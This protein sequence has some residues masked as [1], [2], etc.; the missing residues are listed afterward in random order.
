[1]EHAHARRNTLILGCASTGAKFTPLN[2]APTGDDLLDRICTGE[3]IPTALD[4][5]ANEASDLYR[6]GCRYYHYHARNPITREQT[7][8]NEVYQRVSRDVQRRCKD[9]L[10][11]F[12]ASRNGAEVQRNICEF[13]EWERVSQCALPLHLGGAHFVTIQAAIELQVICDLERKRGGLD[14]VFAS[15]PAFLEALGRFEPSAREEMAKLDTNSTSKGADYGSTSPLIQYRVYCN[16]IQARRNLGLF[17][18][19]EWVQLVRSHA[20]TRF[21]VEHPQ[22]RLGSSGQ[23]NIIL[24]FGFSPKLPFPQDYEEFRAVVRLAKSLEYDIGHSSRRARKVTVTVGAAVMP[25]HAPL[26]YR[27]LDVGPRRGEAMC[28][29]RRLAACAAQP[30]SGV[31]VLRVGMEDTPYAVDAQGQ[32]RRGDNRL[33]LRTAL[34]VLDAHGVAA[35]TDAEWIAARMGLVQAREVLLRAQRRHPLGETATSPAAESAE[36]EVMA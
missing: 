4:D 35:E 1:M 3:S 2:H 34:D 22:M 24:L 9:M 31:D 21:A 19:V 13:G 27:P 23:L 25:R 32:V 10:L 33:L 28:A 26:H 30:D 11:S 5:V 20:M 6:V 8:D 12:G 17:H 29:L 15:S 7:T 16:A 14:T 36:C 18:E